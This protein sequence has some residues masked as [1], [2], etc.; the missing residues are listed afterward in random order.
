MLHLIT[1]EIGRLNTKLKH[2]DIYNHWL[3]Q[4]YQENHISICYV[5][6]KKMI[7]DGLT[8]ALLLDDHCQFLDQLN[9]VDIRDHLI[10]CQNQKAAAVDLPELMN[11]D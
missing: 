11:I 2:V 1:A 3:C 4:E 5:A 8:K 9:L 7:A 10:D 6:L